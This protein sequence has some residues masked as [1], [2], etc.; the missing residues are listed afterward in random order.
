MSG[1]AGRVSKGA[2]G[3]NVARIFLVALIPSG[4]LMPRSRR[5]ARFLNR[6]DI[7][8]GFG[9]RHA[10]AAFT[11]GVWITVAS[12]AAEL[13]TNDIP[14]AIMREFR[15]AWIA[16]VGNLNW[17][18]KPGLPSDQQKAE[19]RAILDNA[20]DLKLNAILFQ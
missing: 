4:N 19:L 1:G 16:T 13:T 10:I 2:M 15:G 7:P 18:S 12:Y 14:P 6:L 3:M 8:L 17:P 5:L 20:V 9:V 11:L